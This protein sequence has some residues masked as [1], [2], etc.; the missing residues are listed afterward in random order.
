MPLGGRE[1]LIVGAVRSPV[2]RGHREKG[3]FAPL[4]PLE[5]LGQTYEGL[6]AATGADP[7]EVGSLTCGTVYTMA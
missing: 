7:A 1:A 4:H 6:F 5:L 2:G 3:A